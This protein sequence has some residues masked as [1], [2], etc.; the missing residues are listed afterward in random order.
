MILNIFT[1]YTYNMLVFI[2]ISLKTTEIIYLEKKRVEK[3]K[4]KKTNQNKN[5]R[6]NIIPESYNKQGHG[7]PECP[8]EGIIWIC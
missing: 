4:E 6:C 1:Y 5:F 3:I 8:S 2:K 7:W